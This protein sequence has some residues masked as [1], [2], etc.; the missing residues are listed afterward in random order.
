EVRAGGEITL[1]AARAALD[2]LKI[3]PEGFDELD[4]RLLGL[5]VENFDGG[6]VGVESL[7]AALSEDRG[8]L[9]DVVEPYLIQQ[10][11]LVRT[12][13]G[14]MISSKGWPYLGLVPPSRQAS[15]ADLFSGDAGDVLAARH[16]V[17][18]A[19]TSLLGGHRRRRRRLSRRL[20]ALHGARPQRV[21][22]RA[23]G[24]PDGVQASHRAGLHGA[25]HADRLPQARPAG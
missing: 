6:P 5:I 8:T 13:R 24:R 23:R 4:R 21:D 9:E 11:Y 19:G 25:R 20:S 12:A 17:P 15:V 3:D 14:R 16:A 10:G 1:P 22:A 18:L 7:A 2:M